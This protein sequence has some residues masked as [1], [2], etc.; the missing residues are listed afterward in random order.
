MATLMKMVN[1]SCIDP[2]RSVPE[3]VPYQ[4]LAMES[5]W[6]ISFSVACKQTVG[7]LNMLPI[8]DM[9]LKLQQRG[10]GGYFCPQG[11]NTHWRN[12]H[13]TLILILSFNNFNRHL[14]DISHH[15]WKIDLVKMTCFQRRFDLL[16]F[17]MEVRFVV[18]DDGLETDHTINRWNFRYYVHTFPNICWHWRAICG[19]ILILFDVT[20]PFDTISLYAKAH[21]DITLSRSLLKR[22][23]QISI[24][25]WLSEGN[26]FNNF[27]NLFILYCS[28]LKLLCLL[29][30]S[31]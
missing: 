28:Q 10:E 17:S 5:G 6:R 11:T 2:A 19:Q 8:K 23:F 9:F 16:M 21:V 18:C 22:G 13:C 24:I 26:S 25:R 12:A 14:E 7:K 20:G 15:M 1:L 29:L 31:I 27:L 30:Q 4:C 3:C